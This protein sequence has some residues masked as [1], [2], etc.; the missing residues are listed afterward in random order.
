[1]KEAR[2]ALVLAEVA[3]QED[4]RR[5]QALRRPQRH[6]RVNAEDPCLVRGGG[7]DA[8]PVRVAA[9][10]HGAAA[11]RRVA[12]LLDGD[13]KRVQVDVED[14]PRHVSAYSKYVLDRQACGHSAEPALV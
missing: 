11:Q 4:R 6:A 7:D 12:R 2:D 5:R 8:A 9:D 14:A 1:M 3:A 10:D 13:E